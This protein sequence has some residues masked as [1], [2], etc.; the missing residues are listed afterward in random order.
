M[1]SKP[2]PNDLLRRHRKL[3]AWSQEKLADL[4]QTDASLVRKWERGVVTPRPYHQEKLCDLFGVTADQ[5]GFI[6]PWVTR[7]GVAPHSTEIPLRGG[8]FFVEGDNMNM[9]RRDVLRL[10]TIASGALALPLPL[11]DWERIEATVMRPK[12]LDETAVL[13]LEGVNTH[14][15]GIYRAANNKASVLDGAQGHFKTLVPAL[16]DPHADRVHM[17]LC[18]VASDLAQ[19]IGEI[20]FD[21]RDYGAAQSCYS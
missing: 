12:L 8:L 2:T 14:Y 6:E 18:A 1:E 7:N 16:Q 17:R 3:H 13:H 5:L 20:Y 9:R 19:L 21:L 10:L 15:W 11:L 4:V